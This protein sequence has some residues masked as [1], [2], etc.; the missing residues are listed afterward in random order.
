MYDSALT[1][2]E[3]DVDGEDF[4]LAREDS[5]K[6]AVMEALAFIIQHGFSLRR[7]CELT[8]ADPESVKPKINAPGQL[9][10][11]PTPEM[12]ASMCKEIRRI[13]D[14]KRC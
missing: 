3:P 5:Q 14:R 7:A 13:S 6:L 1:D 8:G 2:A 12:I 9:P 11:V 4:I 10:P